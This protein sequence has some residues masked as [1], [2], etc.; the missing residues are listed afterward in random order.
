MRLLFRHHC[1]TKIMKARPQSNLGLRKERKMFRQ[2]WGNLSGRGISRRSIST[3]NGYSNWWWVCTKDIQ[4]NRRAKWHS[5]K[6]RGR[7]TKLEKAKLKKPIHVEIHD[8]EKGGDWDEKDKAKYERKKQFEKS[9]QK[10]WLW[11]KRWR[12]YN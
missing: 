12:R 10:P 8:K 5:R 1:T 7:F 4:G 6:D 9:L 11:K 3:R 2:D